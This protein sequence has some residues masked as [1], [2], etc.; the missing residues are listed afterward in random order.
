MAYNKIGPLTDV[1]L[2]TFNPSAGSASGSNAFI[3]APFKGYVQE[4]GFIPQVAVTSN[5]T[6]R[7][8][9]AIWT[10]STASVL[11]EIISST[12][13]SFNSVMLVA[14]NV[15]SV[16]VPSPAYVNAGD[17][18]MLTTS[19]GNAVTTGATIYT[20]IRRGV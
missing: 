9:T 20:I 11:T 17:T 7:V 4:C 5:T 1:T 12:L 10:S 6:L 18:I 8:Q 3:V 16:A 14:G 19:G 13:G 15:A 2:T